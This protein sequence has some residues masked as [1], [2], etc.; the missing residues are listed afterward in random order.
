MK[1]IP[2]EPFTSIGLLI[3]RVGVGGF[4]AF[5]HGLPKLTGFSE[6]AARF[7][8][9]IGVGTTASLALAIFAELF[10]A[11]ALVL[12][13]FTRAVALPLLFT[14]LVAGLIVHADDPWG[15]KEFALLYAIPFLTLMLTGGGRYSLDTLIAQRL[16]KKA[17]STP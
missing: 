2:H 12:G 10:C 6:M 14:M 9:P 13:L 7:A 11:L 4:M 17:D 5:A 1:T 3:L 16:G 8:D 15:K